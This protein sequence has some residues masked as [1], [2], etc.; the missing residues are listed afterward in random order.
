MDDLRDD[1]HLSAIG[2]LQAGMTLRQW[3]AGQALSGVIVATQSEIHLSPRGIAT[4]CV[5]YADALLAELD[6]ET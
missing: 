4:D 1:V 6:K 5:K 3:Y 2:K